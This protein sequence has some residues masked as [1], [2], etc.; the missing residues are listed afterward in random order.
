[1]SCIAVMYITNIV[2][3]P[4]KICRIDA[5]LHYYGNFQFSFAVVH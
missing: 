5:F 1:M 3:E 2:Y 4:F